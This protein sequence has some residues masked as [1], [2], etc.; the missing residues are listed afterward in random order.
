MLSNY[1]LARH[2]HK[3]ILAVAMAGRMMID[4][5]FSSV[6]SEDLQ[7]VL[8]EMESQQPDRPNR[9]AIPYAAVS[10]DLDGMDDERVR[11]EFRFTKS[12]I[13]QILPHLRLDEIQWSQRCRP[14]SLTAFCIVLRRLAYPIRP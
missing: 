2:R 9:P 8:A 3:Q 7:H 12:E 11:Y 1:R 6:E 4:G 14:D 10:F 13:Y 5:L